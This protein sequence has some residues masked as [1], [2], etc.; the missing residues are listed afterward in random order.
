MKKQLFSAAACAAVLCFASSA[1]AGVTRLG[2]P[3]TPTGANF[4]VTAVQGVDE[5]NLTGQ[6]GNPQVNQDFEIAGTTGVTYDN[7]GKLTDFGLGLYQDSSKS[8]EST[9]IRVDY[10]QAVTAGSVHVTLAD[11]DIK[12]GDTFFNVNKVE[13]TLLLL[14]GN[15]IV[16]VAKPS[17]IFSAM[18]LVTTGAVDKGDTWDLSFAKVLQNLNLNSNTQINGFI[19]AADRTA[20]EKANSDPYLLVNIGNGI[21]EVPEPSSY[22]AGAFAIAVAVFGHRH[23]RRKQAAQA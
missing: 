23:M 9:G 8:T 11:F 3:F 22:I 2:N 17:D 1:H 5:N 19:L 14:S 10:N 15:N 18:T 21:P 13:P 16:A 20:G 6:G 4:T 7:S 12:S